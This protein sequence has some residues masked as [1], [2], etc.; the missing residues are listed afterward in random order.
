MDLHVVGASTEEERDLLI[1]MA[2][3]LSVGIRFQGLAPRAKP[4]L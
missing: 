4:A 1:E 2:R 3:T